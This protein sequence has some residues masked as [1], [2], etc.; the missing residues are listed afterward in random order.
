MNLLMAILPLLAATTP[1]PLVAQAPAGVVVSV[2]VNS[3]SAPTVY[4]GWP[5]ILTVAVRAAPGKAVKLATT[6]PWSGSITLGVSS[7]GSR[8]QWPLVMTGTTPAS[9]VLGE[10][11]RADAVWT[12]APEFTRGLAPGTYRITAALDTTSTAAA[13]GWKGA[14]TA[15]PVAVRVI[16]EPQTPSA[17]D[18][19]WKPLLESRYAELCG[20]AARALSTLD[21]WLATNPVSVTVLSRKAAVLENMNRPQEA[22]AVVETAL[23]LFYKAHPQPGEPPIGLIRQQQALTQALMK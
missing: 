13:G 4:R 7:N 17:D 12:V 18:R 5:L 15:L 3:V 1:A 22:L 10:F 9:V 19:I 21:A 11:D 2:E 6:A 16:N 20:D 23:D 8:V 14:A